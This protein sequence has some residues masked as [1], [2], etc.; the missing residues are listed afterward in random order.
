MKKSYKCNSELKKIIITRLV[1]TNV[2]A[3][4]HSIAFKDADRYVMTI[5]NLLYGS[6]II[7]LGFKGHR[8]PSI[9]KETQALLKKGKTPKTPT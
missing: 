5:Y 4:E 7:A 2:A 1:A 9:K 6:G 3:H 8:Y